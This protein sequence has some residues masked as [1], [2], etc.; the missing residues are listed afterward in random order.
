M[1]IH[2][3]IVASLFLLASLIYSEEEYF[4]QFVHYNM[5][6]TLDVKNHTLSGQSIID[7]TN[8]SPDELANIYLHLLPNAFQIGS[9]KYR[10]YMQR[11]GHL[12]RAAKF[13]Q[14][15]ESYFSHIDVSHFTINHN[16]VTLADSFLIDD[17]ILSASLSRPLKPGESVRMKF[18]WVHYIGE[19]V[20]RAG[21][22]GSQY[23]LAQ[24]YPKIVVY[25]QDGWHHDPFHAS[26]EFYGEFGTFDVTIDVPDYYTVGATGIVTSG[27]PGWQ[28]IAVDTTRDF[29]DWLK[30]Y[31]DTK[32]EIDSSL[33]R[34]VTFHAENVHDFAWITSPTFL[35][36]HGS[37]NGIDVHVLFNEKNGEKWTRKVRERSE[38]ALAWLSTQFGAYPYPQVTTTDRLKG[39][40]MEYPMLVMNG[41]ERE[42]LIIHEIGHIWFYGI[43]GNN[44]LD[45][46]WLDEGFT[47]FQTREYLMNRY[48]PHGFDLKESER[49]KPFE[50]KHRKFAS[51]LDRNQWSVIRYQTSGSDEPISRKSFMF[52]HSGSYRFNAYT[53]PSLMLQELK[54]VLGDSLFYQSMQ[55]YYQRWKLK[56]PTEEQFVSTVEEVT[57]EDLDWFFIP[58]LHNTRLLDYGIKKWKKTK[59]NNGWDMEVVIIKRGTR[60]MPQLLEV[61]MKDGSKERIWWR[62]QKWR[63]QDTF[64]FTLNKEPRSI[65]L[66]PDV[67]TLDVDRRNNYSRKMPIETQ[68]NWIDSNY[69]PRDKYVL[70]WFPTLDYHDKDGYIPGFQV[71]RK[72][73]NWEKLDFS[74]SYGEESKNVYW[75]YSSNRKP[76]HSFQGYSTSIHA[77]DL[78]AVNGYGMEIKN[79]LNEAFAD[80]MSH[81]SSI[82]FYVTNT[83]DTSR[84]NLYDLGQVAVIFGK[85][86][87]SFMNKLNVSMDIATTPDFASHWSFSRFNAIIS[88]NMNKDKMGVRNRTILGRMV[89]KNGVP[90]QERYTIEGAGS[91]DAYAKPFLRDESSFYGNV[92]LRN[93]YHL[94]G[95]ANLRG[96]FGEKLIGAESIISNSFELYFK[97]S[98]KVIDIEFAAFIDD[99]WIWGSKYLPGDGGFNGEYL[100][101]A[102][103]GLRLQKTVLGKIFYIRLDAPFLVK[104]ISGKNEGVGIHR[105]KW[106]FSFSKSI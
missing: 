35:Y 9:V 87:F 15:T 28:S 48:G 81:Y 14:G 92:D 52:N 54:Y 10:E 59:T 16:G 63:K 18:N 33:R 13:I 23:N 56:H 1:K 39:G 47:T 22:V 70:K 24:W 82:G 6:V 50:K 106:L 25:D 61:T 5:D 21:R 62:N 100:L 57:R 49:Y 76:V 8:H 90:A 12:G 85:Y 64:N 45:E 101:D 84:T 89:S 71:S 102:G 4:Q 40:G 77:Y 103:V 27:D 86:S 96:Y 104:D 58:W 99:G 97:P 67:Q 105:D 60:E 83:A 93:H 42:G 94:V 73:G 11:F 17:T 26:G 31:Q 7:Y 69:N 80:F 79:H 51:A 65:V 38:N 29:N 32:T 75:S 91:G 41:S 20:E 74:L 78:G 95:D 44:E 53:K 88:F 66:D 43:L 55:E 19:Q 30:E 3:F 2:L 72:Y 46:A 68:F 37:W 98:I 36:E 34:S